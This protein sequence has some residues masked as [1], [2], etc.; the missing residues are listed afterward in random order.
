MAKPDVDT[1]RR[2]FQ[3][4]PASIVLLRGRE[5]SIELIN[6]ESRRIRPTDA[7]AG[8]TMR[9]AWPELEGQGFFE[10]VEQVYDTQQAVRLPEIQLDIDR[11]GEKLTT[12]YDM[13]IQPR[14][15]EAGKSFGVFVFA[16]DTTESVRNRRVLDEVRARLEFA[17]DAGGIGT[18]E[19]VIPTNEVIWTPQ[20]EDQ[21][22]IP[23]GSFEGTYEAWTKRVHPDDLEMAV[24]WVQKAVA[25]RK[26]MNMEYR[27]VWPDGTVRWLLAR[28][29]VM[30]DAEG[31]PQRFIGMSI[32][33]TDSKQM[34]SRLKEAN[35]RI[36]N[37]LEEILD[38]N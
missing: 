16:I 15:D 23:R 35:D 4:I 3:E 6:A 13:N 27:V 37:I 11:N 2:I 10:L 34:E 18:F 32:D 5:G 31:E 26:A 20:L 8:Q 38:G 9:E 1:Y 30:L 25:G 17:Q 19:W 7:T 36:T 29:K 21:Y 33:I 22:N 14:V 12:Y 24:G 28:A